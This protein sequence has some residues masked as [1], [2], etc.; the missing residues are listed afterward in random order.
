MAARLWFK[1]GEAAR[2][3]SD[4]VKIEIIDPP[5]LP[6]IPVGPNRPLF[7]TAVLAAGIGAGLVMG[8]N[9]VMAG[10]RPEDMPILIAA[11]LPAFM[12]SADAMPEDLERA[13]AS[14]FQGYWTKPIDFTAFLRDLEAQLVSATAAARARNLSV[15][16]SYPT[17]ATA[18]TAS[19]PAA[20]AWSCGATPTTGTPSRCP[21]T[22]RP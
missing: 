3:N 2:T 1:I 15:N 10:C 12:C 19:R 13:R 18:P 4:R 22:S 16:A 5:T 11:A 14:G 7:A 21:A 8:S 9:G 6:S 17:E 20:T